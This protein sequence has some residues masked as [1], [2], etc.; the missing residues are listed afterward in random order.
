MLVKKKKH[1]LRKKG[2]PILQILFPGKQAYL[3]ERECGVL[4]EEGACGALPP[5]LGSGDLGLDLRQ[6]V[7]S[8]GDGSSLVHERLEYVQVRVMLSV[9]HPIHLSKIGQA[10]EKTKLAIEILQKME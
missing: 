1:H 4:L 7:Q 8:H 3:D 6:L 9:L 2:N 5:A 10:I